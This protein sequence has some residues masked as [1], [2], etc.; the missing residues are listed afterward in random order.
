MNFVVVVVV[1]ALKKILKFQNA[2]DNKKNEIIINQSIIDR[3]ISC[4]SLLLLL[5]LLFLLLLLWFLPSFSSPFFCLYFTLSTG[6]DIIIDYMFV[7]AFFCCCC[8]C[9]C[10]DNL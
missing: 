6:Y 3:L 2:L 1:V 7:C 8:C 4:D 9:C 10:C 5:L